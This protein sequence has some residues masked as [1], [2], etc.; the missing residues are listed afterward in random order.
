MATAGSAIG[1]RFVQQTDFDDLV[2]ARTLAPGTFYYTPTL[3]YQNYLDRLTFAGNAIASLQTIDA[4]LIADV[5][6]NDMHF[7]M[8]LFDEKSA[9][10]TFDYHR[11]C[12][13]IANSPPEPKL[14]TI[15]CVLLPWRVIC[16][17]NC[18]GLLTWVNCVMLETSRQS[19]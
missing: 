7:P 10:G 2:A 8:F 13:F 11:N 14:D 6:D 9:E 19:A 18:G 17:S 16:T 1:F 3:I 15:I 4:M 5:V 12:T